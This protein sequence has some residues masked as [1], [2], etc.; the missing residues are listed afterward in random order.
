MKVS[1]VIAATLMLGAAT[2]ALAQDAPYRALGTEP[3]WSLTIDSRMM[4]FQVPGGR[5]IAVATPKVINGFAGEI[6]QTRRMNVNVVHT[7][8]SD[9][10]SDRT[11]HDRV[12]V[13]LDGKRYEGCGGAAAGEQKPPVRQ[14][15]GVAALEGSAWRIVSVDGMRADTARPTS[16]HFSNG[17]VEGNAGCNSF[18][19]TY[20][21]AGIRLETTRIIST[22][23][24]CVGPGMAIEGKVFS[25]LT[26]SSQLIYNRDATLTITSGGSRMTLARKRWA[27]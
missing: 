23:M 12:T 16:I 15:P 11:Y 7:S 13:M 27:R 2:P 1:T 5:P 24:A 26:G 8:C 9:G 14:G 20:R 18:G 3:F 6:Y 17:R 21:Q 19:G 22:K 25:I 10:M 4:T